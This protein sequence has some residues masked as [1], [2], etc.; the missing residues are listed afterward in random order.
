MAKVWHQ[1]RFAHDER[2]REKAEQKL[3]E[4]NDAYE[5][6]LS[7]R[8]PRP[9]ART[10]EPEYE[11]PHRAPTRRLVW[12]V[13]ALL[14]FGAA[15]FVTSRSLLKGRTEAASQPVEARV[16]TN[17]PES[18]IG[19]SKQRSKEPSNR[20][21][22]DARPA[23]ETEDQIPASPAT[24]SQPMATV[25]VLI[26]PAN[27]L[28]ARPD[29]PVKT[30]MTYPANSQP[31]EYCGAVHQIKQAESDSASARVKSIAKRVVSPGKWLGSERKET[32]VVKQ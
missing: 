11:R 31:H 2:L 32:E 22:L 26:D 3:K 21:V 5:Q 24:T 14:I 18:L 12:S 17:E 4:I 9:A 28:L 20:A 16:L 1:D 13:T 30:K 29:C 8:T 19:D 23:N 27:G 10:Y 7:G 15:F 25:T 6:L